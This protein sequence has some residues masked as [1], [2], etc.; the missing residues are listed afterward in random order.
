[1][2]IEWNKINPHCKFHNLNQWDEE[3]TK[4]YCTIYAPAIN[5][6][7]NCDIALTEEDIK[8]IANKQVQKNLLSHKKGGRGSDWVKAVYDFVKEN[9]SERG[10]KVPNLVTLSPSDTTL[11]KSFINRG[12]AVTIWI[13]VSKNFYL[14]VADDRE[15]NDFED[16]L[17]Y[18]GWIWHFTN[19]A[20]WIKNNPHD[21]IIDSYFDRKWSI[22]K[23]DIDKVLAKI[24]MRTKYVF[25]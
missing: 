5:L 3:L 2:N 22:Y 1:M 9:A 17:N 14:D 11:L 6:K 18:F 12:Y 24:A 7:Y 10:W 20:K 8:Y 19:I 13:K 21:M 25:F 16:Y 23:V 4:M 15:L